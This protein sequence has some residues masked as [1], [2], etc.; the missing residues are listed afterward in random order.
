M[1]DVSN[2]AHDDA[3]CEVKPLT[4]D[5]LLG[6]LWWGDP[7]WPAYCNPLWRE[8]VERKHEWEAYRKAVA[9]VL[10]QAEPLAPEDAPEPS[11]HS[12]PKAEATVAV[13]RAA[14]QFCDHEPLSARK[15]AG[16]RVGLH[17]AVAKLRRLETTDAR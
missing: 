8:Y 11:F 10:R 6:G 5:E 2:N 14:K 9:S 3:A 17:R 16:H 15:Q 7:E 4:D 12:S 1:A 13:V